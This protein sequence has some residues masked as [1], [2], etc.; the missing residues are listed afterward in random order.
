MQ[1]SMF[2]PKTLTLLATALTLGSA[3]SAVQAAMLA[4]LQDGKYIV[5]ID[6]DQK[7]V[8]GSVKLESG[9]SLIG[10]DVRPADGKLYGV[11]TDGAIVIVDA[12]SGKLEKKSQA[13]RKTSRRG[14]LFGRFQSRG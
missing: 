9:A 13:L 10:I 6:T 8:T 1:L 11:T 4:G 12:K 3:S 5:W 14:H 2:T 7:K